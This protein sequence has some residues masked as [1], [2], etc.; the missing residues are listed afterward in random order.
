MR[1][2]LSLRRTAGGDAANLEFKP[3]RLVISYGN[4]G[5]CLHFFFVNTHPSPQ[6]AQES[7]PRMRLMGKGD[8]PNWRFGL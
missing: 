8:C 1:L 4:A 3:I 6:R 7:D 2:R 5:H